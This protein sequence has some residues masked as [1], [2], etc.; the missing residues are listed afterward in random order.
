MGTFQKKNTTSEVNQQVM[1]KLLMTTPH[2]TT[3]NVP[4]D[5]KHFLAQV[6]NKKPD[7][8]KAQKLNQKE[9]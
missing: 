3:L 8:I 6:I 1:N 4:L 7:V 2:F 5:E 9:K